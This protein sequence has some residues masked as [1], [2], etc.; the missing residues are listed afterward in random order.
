MSSSTEQFGV[1]SINNVTSINTGIVLNRVTTV[2]NYNIEKSN[3]IIGV[4]STSNSVTVTLPDASTLSS[5]HA[6]IV[7]DEG[8]AAFTNNITISASGSQKLMTQIQQFY[9]Y[10]I[11]LFSF[12]VTAP[13]NSLFSKRV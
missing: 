6:F 5:G 11:H 7:K 4:D 1:D 8:G 3:Y 2:T 12:I 10:R 9:R 13:T